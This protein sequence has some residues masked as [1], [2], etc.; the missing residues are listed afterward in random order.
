MAGR[1]L[2]SVEEA[3]VEI[4]DLLE[5]EGVEPLPGDRCQPEQSGDVVVANGTD[6]TEH[7]VAQRLGKAQPRLRVR[8]GPAAVDTLEVACLDEVGEQLGDVQGVGPGL[9]AQR[10][11]QFPGPGHRTEIGGAAFDSRSSTSPL[12]EFLD[13][14]VQAAV[15]PAGVG[16]DGGELGRH[17]GRP[18]GGDDHQ[19][20][21][22]CQPT[23]WRRSCTVCGAAQ[24]TS[25]ST[26]RAV[27]Q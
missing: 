27:I 10:E 23:R 4:V 5:D 8:S 6:P 17:V 7:D 26:T 18:V 3:P 13:R 1:P 14:H 24:W 11:R 9:L 25:S 21:S 15:E 2:E 12:V 20:A 19:R 16:D 22:R